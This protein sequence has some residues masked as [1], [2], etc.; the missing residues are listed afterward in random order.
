MQPSAGCINLHQILATFIKS[1]T[2]SPFT[3][4]WRP[5]TYLNFCL[6]SCSQPGSSITTGLTLSTRRHRSCTGRRSNSL[7]IIHHGK[8]GTGLLGVCGEANST[9][10]A[11]TLTA[12]A[13]ANRPET[14]RTCGKHSSN[15]QATNSQIGKMSPTTYHH[16]TYH[17][18][19]SVHHRSPLRVLARSAKL[20]HPKDTRGNRSQCRLAAH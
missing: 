10:L 19:T 1:A 14:G 18:A 20:V 11:S 2:A 9:V 7:K 8:Q 16:Y 6:G 13:K 5:L 3:N 4:P 17:H 12:Q 15:R